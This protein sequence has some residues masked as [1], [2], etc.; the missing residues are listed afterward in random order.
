MFV[1]KIDVIIQTEYIFENRVNWNNRF[2]IASRNVLLHYFWLQMSDL[3]FDKA[4][5]WVN[6]AKLSKTEG[7]GEY[8]THQDVPND[9]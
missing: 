1:N 2:F 7:K 9:S 6:R 3:K 5:L 4:A 8:L